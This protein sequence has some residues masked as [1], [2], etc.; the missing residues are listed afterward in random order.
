MEILG[1][2]DTLES[3]ILEGFR[4]PL[5]KKTMIDEEKVLQVIDKIR[6]VAQGGGGLVRD[7]L[8][9]KRPAA[10]PKQEDQDI[11]ETRKEVEK[12]KERLPVSSEK[13]GKATELIENAYKIAKEVRMGADKYADEVLS[14]LEATSS[15]ILRSVKAGRARLGRSVTG[16]HQEN[17][18]EEK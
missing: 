14:S 10:A 13:E 4:V 9:N 18:V 12:L 2:L 6:L 3:M 7:A 15:R 5:S 17:E 8:N 16:S 1:L 11:I